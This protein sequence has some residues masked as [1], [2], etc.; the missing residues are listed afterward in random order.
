MC[1]QCIPINKND[2]Q[3]THNSTDRE[4]K[5]IVIEEHEH[6]LNKT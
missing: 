6:V 2:D 5:N 1:L 4:N 3:Q